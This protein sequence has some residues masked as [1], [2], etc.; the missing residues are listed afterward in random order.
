MS[1]T[2]NANYLEHGSSCARY[3]VLTLSSRS[4]H[5]LLLLGSRFLVAY[6][7]CELFRAWLVMC[8]LWGVD[9]V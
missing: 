9:F 5:I 7:Q 4:S 8:T 2:H 6:P 3:G 1:P